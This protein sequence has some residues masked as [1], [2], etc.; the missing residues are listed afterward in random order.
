MATSERIWPPRTTA[1]SHL[2]RS[3]TS[4]TLRSN[5]APRSPNGDGN[6]KTHRVDRHTAPF[7]RP[8]RTRRRASTFP[9]QSPRNRSRHRLRLT[10]ASTPATPP[11]KPL[12]SPAP[13][14]PVKARL[15]PRRRIH[16][17]LFPPRRR[18]RN[19]ERRITDGKL[20]AW[21]FHNYQFRRFRHRDSLRHPQP[22]HPNSILSIRRFCAAALIVA[23]LPP[24]I[25]SRA[26][27][28]WTNSRTPPAWIPSNFA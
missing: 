4:P 8:H 10:A 7:R 9:K 23:W 2:Q 27:L 19:Q 11:S 15:D 26:N 14:T 20:T 3:P 17:G 13:P 28:T 1:R 21:E 6:G 24:P 16:L 22:A 18:H 25:T 12:A 5:L